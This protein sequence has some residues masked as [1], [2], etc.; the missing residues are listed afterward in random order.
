M[1]ERDDLHLTAHAR[2]GLGDWR[3]DYN[4]FQPHSSPGNKTPSE[5][6]S[7]IKRPKILLK[8]GELSGFIRG[9]LRYSPPPFEGGD[10][11]FDRLGDREIASK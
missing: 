11:L 8:S 2:E 7:R 10:Y 5:L 4:H 9:R 3:L 6:E 1:C